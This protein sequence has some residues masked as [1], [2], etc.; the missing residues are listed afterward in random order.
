MTAR[1]PQLRGYPVLAVV[2][3]IVKAI[4]VGLGY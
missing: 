2:M 4:E 1:Q 3:L